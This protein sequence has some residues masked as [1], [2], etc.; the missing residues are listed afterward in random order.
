[1]DYQRGIFVTISIILCFGTFVACKH[2]A[3]TA[4]PDFPM[5]YSVKP[6][7]E[8]WEGSLKGQLLCENLSGKIQIRYNNIVASGQIRVKKD[9]TIW[10]SVSVFGMEAGRIML[11]RDTVRFMNRWQ[12][13]Y[14]IADYDRLSATLGLPITYDFVQSVLLGTDMKEEKAKSKRVLQTDSFVEIHYQQREIKAKFPPIDQKLYLNKETFL[15]AENRMEIPNTT[16]RL[17]ITYD[18]WHH[19]EPQISLPMH[20]HAIIRTSEETNIDVVFKN[21]DRAKTL[22]F[23]FQ[24]PPSYNQRQ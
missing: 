18:Q 19:W 8:N 21:I 23:P 2:N 7:P 11:T 20:L 4:L 10:I 16:H 12:R 15:L 24:I 13:E 9:E 14:F 3:E 22:S 17:H 1:M 5:K 6:L